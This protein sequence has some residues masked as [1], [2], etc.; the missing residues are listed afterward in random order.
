MM[1]RV[2]SILLVL[3]VLGA[4]CAPTHRPPVTV[5]PDLPHAVPDLVMLAGQSFDRC[6]PVD[7][8]ARSLAAAEAVLAREPGHP[9]ASLHAARAAAWLLEFDASL[10]DATR[11]DLAGR[12][13]GYAETAL[14]ANGETV[15]TVLLCGALI[16]LKLEAARVPLPGKLG[17]VTDCFERAVELDPGFND[18]APRVALGTLLVKA[19]DW[20]AG[21]GDIERGIELLTRAVLK[22]R[23]HPANHYY[24][25]EALLADGQREKAERVFLYVTQLCCGG[26][27]SRCEAACATYATRAR[28]QV[29]KL[30]PPEALEGPSHGEQ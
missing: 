9:A 17:R 13:V 24:Y 16:G 4:G 11:R 25:G 18:G 1:P 15:E 21:P 29:R 19:P 3:L 26:R 8:V 30:R 27:A 10:D 28:A 20:P 12:G 22:H 14:A 23:G 7:S 6:G 5:E 2:L